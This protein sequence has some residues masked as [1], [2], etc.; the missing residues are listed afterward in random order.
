MTIERLGLFGFRNF[1]SVS[2]IQFPPQ[3]LLVAAAPNA[4]GKT[5]FLESIV[6][7]LR[8]K[9]WRATSEECT[10]WEQLGFMVEGVVRRGD[11]I[12]SNLRVSYQCSSQR[13]KVEEDK[14]PASIVTFYS[15]YPFTLFL[16]ED[17]LLLIRG[18]AHRRTFL[19]HVLVVVPHY[20]SALVQYQRALKQRN[21]LLKHARLPEEVQ[22]WTELLAD[23]AL[24]LW[25]H[26]ENLAMFLHNHLTDAYERISGE[27]AVFAVKL[28][29]G[30]TR[31]ESFQEALLSSFDHERRYGYTLSGPHRDDLIITVEGKPVHAVFSRG[32]IRSLVVALKLLA[33]AYMEHVTGEEPLLL[34]DD[35][36]S[37]L[38]EGRQ[39]AF[40]EHLPTT[41][42][43]LTC[44]ALPSSLRSRSD[45]HWLDLQ[46][47]IDSRF[48]YRG[49]SPVD[50]VLSSSNLRAEEEEVTLSVPDRHTQPAGEA[51]KAS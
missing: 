6:M 28:S 30:S 18:P 10:Q 24:I 45:V 14:A 41:Q 16:P 7:L 23:H 37:E 36:L 17:T 26:R 13:L 40:L 31:P 22:V 34:L 11:G 44:T 8:G 46:S 42:L 4:T 25:K 51:V 2:D 32:Q 19:N 20:L 1:K 12:D 21:A 15:H 35:A 29:F 47:I 27:R 5:N 38:D 50:K 48:R 43:L 9:S 33:C 49:I 39:Q 3:A